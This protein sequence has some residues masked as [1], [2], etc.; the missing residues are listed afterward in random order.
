MTMPPT[1]ELLMTWHRHFC[2]QMQIMHQMKSLSRPKRSVKGMDETQLRIIL[3]KSLRKY[4]IQSIKLV[5]YAQLNAVVTYLTKSR[6]FIRVEGGSLVQ[7]TK[8]EL[9]KLRCNLCSDS[10]A[11]APPHQNKYDARAK[12]VIAVSRYQMGTPMDRL[13]RFQE[14]VGV[15]LLEGTQWQLILDL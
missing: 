15:P 6:R 3:V 12:A 11:S 4:H 14:Y 1:I 13:A 8:F 9:E 7:A 5:I 2:L 10:F